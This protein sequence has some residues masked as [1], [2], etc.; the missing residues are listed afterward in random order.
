M[1]DSN[2]RLLSLGCRLGD[3]VQQQKG[4]VPSSQS[5]QGVVADL[6]TCFPD[7]QAPLRDL[8]SRQSFA[9][10]LPHARSGGGLIQRDALI[11]EISRVYHPDVLFHVE[12]VL[13]GF[14]DAS[15]GIAISLTNEK[16]ALQ[17]VNAPRPTPDSTAVLAV[18][19][20]ASAPQRNTTIMGKRLPFTGAKLIAVTLAIPVAL[21]VIFAFYGMAKAKSCYAIAGKL[22]HLDPGTAQFKNLI[23]ENKEACAD[24]ARFLVQQSILLLEQK[25]YNQA[26]ML[27]NKSLQIDADSANAN[28]W[29]GS[30][31]KDLKDYD[32]SLSAFSRA[33]ELDP[34]DNWAAFEKAST[35]SYLGRI[36]EAISWYSE[37]IKLEPANAPA[38]RERGRERGLFLE[39]PQYQAALADLDKAIQ[40]DKADK[41]SYQLRAS[42]KT[43]LDD[44]V[45]ACA[46]IKKA[47]QLGYKE[48][49][50][51]DKVI[52]IEQQIADICN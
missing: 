21:P 39:P 22:E 36:N 44:W 3:Y 25:E 23:N 26:L 49:F 9:A 5:L 7:L 20:I 50:V 24:D 41:Y 13:N 35:L 2:P 52:P 33:L 16:K 4:T 29:K 15:G 17:S 47:K 8:V 42:V 32:K 1:S 40:I 34:K 14:L 43:W 19:S 48:G 46:D 31:Y 30:I 11:Q 37:A 51:G 45:G 12:Q 6:A 38:Y 28:Y 18:E 27:I 10:L